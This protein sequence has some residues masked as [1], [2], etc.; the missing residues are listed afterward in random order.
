VEGTVDFIYGKGQAYFENALIYGKSNG[1]FT[2]QGRETAAE[3]SGYVF[4]NATVTGSAAANTF[5]LGRPWGQYSRTVFIDSKMGPQV[6][7]AGWSTWSADYHLTSFYAEHNSMDLN[8]NPL[9]VSQRVSWSHQLTAEDAAAFSKE[10]WLAG[11]DGWNP[12][13][14][15]PLSGDYNNDGFV[16]AADYTV[17]RD[18]LQSGTPLLNETAS[19]GMVDSEDFEEWKSNFGATSGNGADSFSAIPEPSGWLLGSTCF[20]VLAIERRAVM[21]Q[22]LFFRK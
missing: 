3:A 2:A 18:S 12:V 20:L 16:D 4:K 11:T 19:V 14:V 9:N 21:R 13:V 7:A 15:M 5:F 1:Y 8:G 10:N 22:K 17:W 6:K